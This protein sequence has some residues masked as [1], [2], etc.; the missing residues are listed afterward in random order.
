M[1][2]IENLADLDCAINRLRHRLVLL[3]ELDLQGTHAMDLIKE[4]DLS[5]FE[6]IVDS[7]YANFGIYK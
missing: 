6:L 2:E 4:Q 3:R 1:S 7:A 5:D